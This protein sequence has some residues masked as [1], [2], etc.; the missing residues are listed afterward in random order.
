MEEPAPKFRHEKPS[1]AVLPF[2][3][4]S[5]DRENAFFAGGVHEDIITSLAKIG[6]LKVISRTSVMTYGENPDNL[7]K[8]GEELGVSYIVEGSVR[9]F[10]NRV[11]VSAQ[12]I[13]AHTDEHL[14]AANF[15]R[16]LTDVFA[17]QSAIAREVTSQVHGELSPGEAELLSNV[18]TTSVKAYDLYLQAR[19][20]ARSYTVKNLLDS[21]SMLENAVKEDPD[22]SQAWAELANVHSSIVHIETWSNTSLDEAGHRDK[23]GKALN[24]AR[25]L[26][27]EDPM[28]YFASAY[29]HWKANME[30]GE[31][32]EDLARARQYMPNSAEILLAE[33][34]VL[35]RMGR[36][37]EAIA[38]MEK[39]L[40][41][42]PLNVGLLGMLRWGYELTGRLNDA[43][44]LSQNL[45]VLQP[46]NPFQKLKQMIFQ[47][48]A[49]GGLQNLED[50]ERLTQE[51]PEDSIN[52]TWHLMMLAEW[53]NDLDA[54]KQSVASF[55]SN[56]TT[57][58]RLWYFST[59]LPRLMVALHAQGKQSEAEEIARKIVEYVQKGPNEFEVAIRETY[60]S[61]YWILGSAVMAH[62][63]LNENQ[64]AHK[65]LEQ[66]ES[67]VTR[68]KDFFAI[69]V[70]R[71]S[72]IFATAWVNPDEAALLAQEA[73]QAELSKLRLEQIASDH[74]LYRPI[75]LQPRIKELIIEDGKWLDYLSERVP[76][77]A[78]MKGL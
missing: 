55:S 33:G 2:A 57:E 18:P 20:L 19:E 49:T 34:E 77:Y 65:L 70:Q 74:W 5:A 21:V 45:I 15:D 27:P 48:L 43:V 30:N 47:H 29:M 63:I 59:V 67:F 37:K 4:M 28:T 40:P 32:L 54:L 22:F 3:N 60:I 35:L 9:R 23:A 14:W 72:V 41:L 1:I 42:D 56:M 71:Y 66:L 10:G 62:G 58:E 73:F 36:G 53:R 6:N 17:I 24:R 68:E 51:L 52:K 11:K 50:F 39:A 25:A 75:L 8:I 64:Q 46:D 69:L 78:D 44:R 61:G 12:L 26:A 38:K 76:E 7:R 31:A 13:D 16:E